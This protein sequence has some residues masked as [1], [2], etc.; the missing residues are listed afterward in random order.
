VEKGSGQ[1][2]GER[3]FRRRGADNLYGAR[4]SLVYIV[5]YGGGRGSRGKRSKMY[6]FYRATDA[7]YRECRVKL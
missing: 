6:V 3:D 1:M 5:K 4:E 7:V 2:R